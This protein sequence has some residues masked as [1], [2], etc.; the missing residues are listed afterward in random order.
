MKAVRLVEAGRP[1]EL[2]DVPVPAPGPH[3]VRVRVGAAGICHSDAH[4]RAGISSTRTPVTLGHEIAGTIDRV[5][6]SVFHFAVGER[7]CA[8]YLATCG[9]CAFCRGGHEQFCGAGE[10]LGKHRDGGFAEFVVLPAASV[11]ALP[12]TVSFAHGAVMMCSSATAL[13]ALRQARFAPGETV[14]IFGIG[15]LGASAVQLA[16]AL[17]AAAVYAIDLAPAKLALAASFGA[18]PVDANDSDAAE[19]RAVRRA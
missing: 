7:V 17:G 8:H 1:L 11:V 14:A 5:G 2:H 12:G 10:M 9:A 6:E 13:H 4:Y 16:R 3:E 18:I 15:G 19:Q